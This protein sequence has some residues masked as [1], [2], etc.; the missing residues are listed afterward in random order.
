MCVRP[1]EEA[2]PRAA[3]RR[4]RGKGSGGSRGRA[5]GRE[6]RAAMHFLGGVILPYSLALICFPGGRGRALRSV[7]VVGVRMSCSGG[8]ECRV[9][10]QQVVYAE[11]AKVQD[12]ERREQ[13]TTN[14]ARCARVW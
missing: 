8:G 14:R 4:E 10:R 9:G 6:D 12:G 7:C 3:M 11:L 13:G 1:W 5:G 2:R